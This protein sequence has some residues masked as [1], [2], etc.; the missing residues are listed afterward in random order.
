ME[1]SNNIDRIISELASKWTLNEISLPIKLID[2]SETIIFRFLNDL[3]HQRHIRKALL[4]PNFE[5]TETV[6]IFS[7]YSGESSKSRYYTYTFTFA[8]YNTL[9]HFRDGIKAVRKKHELDSPLKKISFKD[10]DYGPIKRSLEEYLYFANNFVNG[11]IF[12]LI[13][14]KKI[15]SLSGQNSKEGLDRISKALK[16]NAFGSWKGA[17]AEKQQRIVQ[18]IAYFCKLLIGKDKK[19]FWMTDHDCIVANEEKATVAGQIL[20]NA[21]NSCKDANKYETI[22]YM[23]MS[24]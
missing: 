24:I 11:L 5:D 6:A 17:V 4:L 21:I 16:D 20:F 9:G 19:I 18:I 10:L 13:V 8:D 22:G 12:T 3:L 2:N 23:L 7:D 1:S 14:D 15:I